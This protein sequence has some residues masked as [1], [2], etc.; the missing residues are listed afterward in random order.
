MRS[1]FCR[2]VAC[3]IS[4]ATEALEENRHPEKNGFFD[5]VMV[6]CLT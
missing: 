2:A 3:H 6:L 1:V 5:I 4:K